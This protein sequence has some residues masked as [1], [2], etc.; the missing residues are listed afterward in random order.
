M[1]N[2]TKK[3][4]IAVSANALATTVKLGVNLTAT[5][6]LGVVGGLKLAGFE[7]AKSFVTSTLPA[8]AVNATPD[9]FA[10]KLVNFG[11]DAVESA[12]ITGALG[13]AECKFAPNWLKST[14]FVYEAAEMDADGKI[15]KAAV[16]NDHGFSKLNVG[17]D[18]VNT[19]AQTAAF[20]YFTQDDSSPELNAVDL[21]LVDLDLVDLDLVDL[22]FG[23]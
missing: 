23:A 21:D 2:L 10:N 3:S 20:K 14:G 7:F 11:V 17:V 15:T 16:Y 1:S 8:L 13:Y 19:F 9:F 5:K 12:A 4:I 18:V 6:A 22:E